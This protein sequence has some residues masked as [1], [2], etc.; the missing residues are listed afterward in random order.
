MIKIEAKDGNLRIETD[1][2]YTLPDV[3]I[4]LLNAQLYMMNKTL[5]MAPAESKDEVKG[6]IYDMVNL[7]MSALLEKF[8]PE[9]EMHPTLTEAA[10]LKAENELLEDEM[11]KMSQ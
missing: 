10:I 4:L 2:S 9:I 7:R 1:E 6:N 11:S 3:T 5:E 8:A